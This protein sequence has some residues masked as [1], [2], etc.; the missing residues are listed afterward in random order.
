MTTR[1]ILIR[2]GET[3]ASLERRF[4]GSTDVELTDTGRTHAAALA[5]RLRQVRIDVIHTSPLR[6]CMQTAEPIA[7]VTGRKPVVMDEI[8]ECNF[9]EWENL[10]LAEI[11]ESHS[12]SMQLWL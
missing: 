1:F 12:E 9:G 7:Q 4:A 6:R 3:P 2:H 5:Q 10:T 8:R 11:L